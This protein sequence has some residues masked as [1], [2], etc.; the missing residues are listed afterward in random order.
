MD[1][2]PEA[3]GRLYCFIIQHFFRE[4]KETSDKERNF[5]DKQ[6]GAPHHVILFLFKRIQRER[7]YD[8]RKSIRHEIY[9]RRGRFCRKGVSLRFVSVPE[10]RLR[11]QRIFPR[12]G[13]KD[14]QGKNRGSVRVLGGLRSCGNPFAR[15]L[16]RQLSS[17]AF[18]R[19]QAEKGAL[20]TVRGFQQGA[21]A[22]DAA[23]GEIRLLQRLHQI[24]A[25]SRRKR[26]TAAGVSADCGILYQQAGRKRLPVLYFQQGEKIYPQRLDHLRTG[27]KGVKQLQCARG[28]SHR[29][30]QRAF[31]LQ[32]ARRIRLRAL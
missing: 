18:R 25:L 10:F 12:G 2:R 7:L 24:Y 15:S 22:Q 27:G 29:R 32:K 4:I 19:R 31:H 13:L 5:S 23:G 11:L 8:G 9:A 26:H 16:R 20:R 3:A 30:V 6:S 17:R 1:I 21:S 28:R 14:D